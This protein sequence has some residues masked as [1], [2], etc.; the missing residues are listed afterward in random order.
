LTARQL[1]AL[2]AI[3]PERDTDL[4]TVTLKS[5]G[6][7][8]GTANLVNLYAQEVVTLTAQMQSEEAAELDRF[9]RGQIEHAEGELE[10]VNQ[11]LLDFSRSAGFY[12]AD[13]ETEA[14]L[15]QLSDVEIR[16]ETARANSKSVDFRI[17]NFERELGR[18][19]QLGLA[20]NK[21]RDARDALSVSYTTNNPV[22]KDA[23][24][25]VTAIEEQ[26]A[27]ETVAG[28]HSL[29]NFR[30]S[31]NTL[32]NDLYLRLLTLHGDRETLAKEL[33]QVGE[34]RA[35]V[36]EKLKSLPE[37]SQR[38]A[39]ISA[40]QQS[41]QAARD[42]LGVRQ[43]EA[44]VYKESSPG[45][46]RLFAKATE[47]SVATN[48]RWKKTLIVSFAAVIFGVGGALFAIWGIEL[49]D[50]RVVSA[51]DLKRITHLPVA[52]R[53]PDLAALNAEE[54]AH[55]RFRAW[56]KLLR[57]LNLQHTSQIAL[58]F[59]SAASGEGKTTIIRHL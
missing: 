42:L 18:Q 51:G 24:D 14:Y 19:N 13:R 23:Q 58:A 28:T 33:A 22:F 37:K 59:T 25:R 45:L 20:L 9:L 21:A 6:S 3:K 50:F 38:Y 16:L 30:Y 40:R 46:Y 41:L 53:L 35:K 17:A 29:A 57:Q 36:G 1:L 32:A 52:I 49:L 11:E 48:S 39:Q 34:L 27:R 10:A 26:M 2:L 44:Q 7:A 54:R 47:E 56:S 12:N 31:E 15:R 43:R 5:N 4:I 55:W 8:P